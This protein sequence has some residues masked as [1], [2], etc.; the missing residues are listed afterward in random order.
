[1]SVGEEYSVPRYYFNLVRGHREV[2]DPEG[3][4]IATN[5]LPREVA[6]ILE[7]MKSEE[8]ELFDI[9]PGWYLVV[10]DEE[11]REVARFP[12]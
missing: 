6:M 4:E 11:D 8:P 9:T 2:I 10:M 12:I 7:E 5:D 3:V 1:M